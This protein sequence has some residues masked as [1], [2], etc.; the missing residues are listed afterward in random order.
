MVRDVGRVNGDD[1]GLGSRQ[2]LAAFLQK[3]DQ[4]FTSQTAA[5]DVVGDDKGVV[6]ISAVAIAD[7]KDDEGDV[8]FC[9]QRSDRAESLGLERADEQSIDALVEQVNAAGDHF[10]LVHLFIMNDHFIALLGAVIFYTVLHGNKVGDVGT[11]DRQ[12]NRNVLGFCG[13][14]RS[15]FLSGGFRGRFCGG[16][17]VGGLC[18]VGLRGRGGAGGAAKNQNNSQDECK[19]FFHVVLLFICVFYASF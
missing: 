12:A 18:I 16:R 8:L 5:A 10:G 11:V 19:Q 1:R 15:F 17:G 6:R 7:V 9:S 2:I 13:V 3:V 14:G 4:V